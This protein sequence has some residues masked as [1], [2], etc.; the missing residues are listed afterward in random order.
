MTII[1]E[2]V[3]H[4]QIKLAGKLHSQQD[5]QLKVQHQR[6]CADTSLNGKMNAS[7]NLKVLKLTISRI[8]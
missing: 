4:R 6:T 5:H 7:R 1:N 3:C 8:L 2:H